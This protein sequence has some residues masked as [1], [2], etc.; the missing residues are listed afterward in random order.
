MQ[1]ADRTFTISEVAELVGKP[2][3]SV[4]TWRKKHY[5]PL[6][7]QGGWHRFTMQELLGV[8]VF[9]EASASTVNYGFASLA[10]SLA[11]QAFREIMENE[12]APYLVGADDPN[13]GDVAKLVYGIEGVQKAIVELVAGERNYGAYAVIDFSSILKRL[14]ARLTERAAG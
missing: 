6:E 3:N 14:F 7:E 11:H 8:A 9:A 10:A 1:N 4:Q 12:A 13:F 2:L 5:F